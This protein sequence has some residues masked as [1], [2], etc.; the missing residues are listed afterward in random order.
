MA[1][2]QKP[3]F[4]FRRNGRIHLN[5][6]GHHFSRLLAAEVWASVVA[7]LDTPCSEV[8]WRVLATHSIR[9]FPLHL[10]TR[11]PSRFKRTLPPGKTR[12]APYRRLG[13][14]QGR[15]GRMRKISPAPA[16]HPR[17]LQPVESRYNIWSIPTQRPYHYTKESVSFCPDADSWF[18]SWC[19]AC[20]KPFRHWTAASVLK[21]WCELA[22]GEWKGNQAR[23]I[24]N[25]VE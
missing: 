8:V 3:D 24:F 4:V 6:R 18:S 17:T 2:A 22:R 25:S 1:H 21:D 16:F 14:L 19:T 11:V 20:R 13:G 10:P 9:Q 15:Y 5:R 12:Y 23:R 7:M